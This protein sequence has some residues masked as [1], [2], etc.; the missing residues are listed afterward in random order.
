M[1]SRNNKITEKN[2]SFYL[3]LAYWLWFNIGR[4]YS[5]RSTSNQE[6]ENRYRGLGRKLVKKYYE[7]TSNESWNLTGIQCK[8]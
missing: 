8:S 7:K 2:N 3:P 4:G 5:D 1:S 6:E